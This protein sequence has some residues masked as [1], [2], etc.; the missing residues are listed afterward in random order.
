MLAVIGND[1]RNDDAHDRGRVVSP[2]GTK[3]G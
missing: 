2:A 1:T 3:G